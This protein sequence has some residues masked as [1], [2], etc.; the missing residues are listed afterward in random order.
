M[1]TIFFHFNYYYIIFFPHP[2]SQ[3]ATPLTLLAWVATT[4][5]SLTMPLTK[6]YSAVIN[7]NTKS[8][9]CQELQA[10]KLQHVFLCYCT[11]GQTQNAKVCIWSTSLMLLVPV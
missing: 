2:P 5:C 8:W 7:K 1:D 4:C 3:F 11:I 10:V 6:V 9:N